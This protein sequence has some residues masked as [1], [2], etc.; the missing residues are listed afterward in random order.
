MTRKEFDAMIDEA[1]KIADKKFGEE[2][3][4]SRFES[5][6]NVTAQ[7]FREKMLPSLT[8]GAAFVSLDAESS[9]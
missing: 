6:K 5:V 7:S 8:N 1:E 3:R 4:A 9:K 2:W